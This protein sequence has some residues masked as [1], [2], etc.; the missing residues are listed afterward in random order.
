MRTLWAPFTFL[1]CAIFSSMEGSASAIEF[2]FHRPY[3]TLSVC[4]LSS[5]E[6][7]T[8]RSQ[9]AFKLAAAMFHLYVQFRQHRCYGRD[10]KLPKELKSLQTVEDFEK[11]KAYGYDK[12]VFGFLYVC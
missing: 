10:Q 2:G 3:L 5:P 1:T 9:L 11:S 4:I 6:A 12:S 7:K 8:D